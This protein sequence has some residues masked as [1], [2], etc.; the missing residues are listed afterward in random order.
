MKKSQINEKLKW[1][2]QVNGSEENKRNAYFA[3]ASN[4]KRKHT[5]QKRKEKLR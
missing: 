1:R 5:N 3:Y 2:N 4:K